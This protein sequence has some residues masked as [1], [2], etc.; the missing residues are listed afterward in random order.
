VTRVREVTREELE[1]RK[2]A[3]LSR[4]GVTYD[5]LAERAERYSLVGD[6]WSAWSELREIGFLLDDGEPPARRTA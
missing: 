2:Q 5:E 6:E 3:I 4:V 1:R